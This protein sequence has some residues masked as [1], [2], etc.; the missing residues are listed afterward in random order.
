MSHGP[1]CPLHVPDHHGGRHACQC[2]A[3]HCRTH[4]PGGEFGVCQNCL[5]PLVVDGR[6]VR[7]AP[8]EESA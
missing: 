5:R 6:V 2:V 7:L 8:L 3:C 4:V 1:E